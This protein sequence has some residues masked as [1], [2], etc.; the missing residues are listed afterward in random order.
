MGKVLSPGRNSRATLV[1]GV[2]LGFFG[3]TSLLRWRARVAGQAA[4]NSVP[5]PAPSA[6]ASLLSPP[7]YVPEAP[8]A[9]HSVRSAD[10]EEAVAERAL[11]LTV[12]GSSVVGRSRQ[13]DGLVPTETTEGHPR[14]NGRGVPLLVSGAILTAALATAFFATRPAPAP[15]GQVLG[16]RSSSPAPAETAAPS[17]LSL[18]DYLVRFG[19]GSDA[20]DKATVAKNEICASGAEQ[21]CLAAINA[22]HRA[23]VDYRT[24]LQGVSPPACLA[25]PHE[26]M[27]A[28]LKDYDA[29]YTLIEAGYPGD[30]AKIDEGT[31]LRAKA[32]KEQQAALQGKTDSTCA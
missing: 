5:L 14:A 32:L 17:T 28:A 20:L 25:A 9:D 19:A 6:G 1:V 16:I 2:V 12:S 31:Q 27:L 13:D 24:Q 18:A 7:P 15:R 29:A 21:E 8:V 30:Q 22:V 23:V 10:T 4:E 3:I 26:M 11:P